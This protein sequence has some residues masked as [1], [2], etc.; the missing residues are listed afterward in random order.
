MERHPK[1]AQKWLEVAQTIYGWCKSNIG[2]SQHYLEN[3]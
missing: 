2:K 1:K 3:D